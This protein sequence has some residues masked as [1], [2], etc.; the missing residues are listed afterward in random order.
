LLAAGYPV[1]AP[2]RAPSPRGWFGLRLD[3]AHVDWGEVAGAV[4][5]SYR[6]AAP[7]KLVRALDAKTS[8][9]AQRSSRA[10]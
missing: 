5:S 9:R 4:E 2:V 10:K 8:S 7:P 1:R 3:L 6:L